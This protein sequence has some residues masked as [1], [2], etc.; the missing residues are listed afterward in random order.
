MR[1]HAKQ[2]FYRSAQLVGVALCL[3]LNGSPALAQNGAIRGT[4]FYQENANAKPE[5]RP[6]V[7]ILILRQDIKGQLKTKTDK[8]G[9]YFYTVQ[10]FGTY[11]VVAHG[12]GYKYQVKPPVRITSTEPLQIDITITPGDGSL[13]PVAQLLAEAQGGGTPEAPAAPAAPADPPEPTAEEK[14]AAAKLKAERERIEKENERA[15]NI[16]EELRR[17]ME[18]GNAAF[19]R[20]DFETAAS[21]YRKALE[22]DDNQPGFL[23]NLASATLE[24]AVK[25]YNAK[26]RDEAKKAFQESGDAAARAVALNDAQPAERRD[27]VYRS[28]A[29]EA[30]RFLAELYADAEAGEKAGKFYSE[31]ADAQTDP[32]KRLEFKVKA[33]D[34][35]RFAGKF[36]Q[37]DEF[38]RA[39]L[40]EDGNNLSAMNGLAMSLL[41]SDPEL[42]DPNKAGEAIALFEMV[43]AK[44]TD[45]NMKQSAQA[46]AEYIR[47]T[48]KEIVRPKP[49]RKRN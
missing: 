8:K 23:G 27:P 21:E 38:Y 2:F 44:A 12:P 30:Y 26:Q 39:V 10:A 48:A 13:P 35:Y 42:L 19:N 7:E 31:L 20:K 37:A 18:A 6:G 36:K 33:G 45:Q 5:P 34:A 29:A 47:T 1:H 22:L 32:K 41:S 14:E 3:G 4:V 49:A 40:Q 15:R 16:N 9:G 28:K 43:A 46:S 17:L 24:I 11:V 25:R